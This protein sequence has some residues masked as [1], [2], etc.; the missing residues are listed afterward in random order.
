[1]V[2]QQKCKDFFRHRSRSISCKL[3]PFVVVL[4]SVILSGCGSSSELSSSWR[5]TDVVI[6]GL[7]TEWGPYLTNLK[8]TH[9]SLGVQNDQDFMYVCLM[10]SDEQFRRQMMARGLTVWIEGEEGKIGV[11]YPIGFLKKGS[12]PAR[13]ESEAEKER[14]DNVSPTEM[15]ILGPGKDDRNLFSTL[16]A[17]GITAKLGAPDG[18]FVYELKI[19]LRKSNV[20]AYAVGAGTASTVK[21]TVETGKFDE[22]VRP[23]G[24]MGEGTRGG[25]MKPRGGGGGRGGRMPG[26]E[27][28]GGGPPRG[29][30]PEPLNVSAMVRLATPTS[31]ISQ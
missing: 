22:G 24:G 6:D 21:L 28:S 7:A 14:I 5:N 26:G 29:S 23:R 27:G 13:D 2:Q 31:S 25:G 15:E 11:H 9:V 20:Q 18:P 16:E 3:L 12:L 19:P 17:P 4:F 10:S 8:D 30:R 1:M